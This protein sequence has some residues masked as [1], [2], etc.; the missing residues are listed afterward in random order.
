MTSRLQDHLR[1]ALVVVDGAEE[2]RWQDVIERS[3]RLKTPL[4]DLLDRVL[5]S[6]G[7]IDARAQDQLRKALSTEE[8]PPMPEGAHQLLAVIAAAQLLEL[9]GPPRRTATDVADIDIAALAVRC[10]SRGTA[11]PVLADL[12]IAADRWLQLR[13]V[14]ARQIATNV[15]SPE[16][17][18]KVPTASAEGYPDLV[19]PLSRL[20]DELQKELGSIAL[21]IG[22]MQRATVIVSE[23]QQMLWWI[24]SA[25]LDTGGWTTALEAAQEL[26]DL[27]VVTPGPASA[28]HLLVRRLREPD[29]ALPDD[30][31][32]D[33]ALPPVPSR[34]SH[35]VPLMNACKSGSRA[36]RGITTTADAAGAFYDELLLTRLIEARP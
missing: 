30:L 34:A 31:T 20:R 13:A 22:A 32:A 6:F 9:F 25:P 26:A 10:L 11:Q 5:L 36:I 7:A 1:E 12:H 21:Q 17:M 18:P 24:A 29:E 14:A 23:Q 4:A 15:Y 3:G 8:A 19:A 16:T 33:L 2:A 35:F 28:S 27:T